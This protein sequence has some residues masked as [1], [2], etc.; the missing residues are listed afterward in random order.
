MEDTK[1][2]DADSGANEVRFWLAKYIVSACDCTWFVDKV[3]WYDN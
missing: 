1:N 3:H 2:E